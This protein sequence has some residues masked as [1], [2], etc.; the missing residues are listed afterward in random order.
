MSKLLK[1]CI[2]V[3]NGFDI[4]VQHKKFERKTTGN[5]NLPDLKMPKL[6]FCCS[7]VGYKQTRLVD[8]AVSCGLIAIRIRQIPS[9][10]ISFSH[11]FSL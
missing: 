5:L 2:G 8:Q 4:Y 1:A 10:T 3:C 7:V 9:S 11:S 6:F